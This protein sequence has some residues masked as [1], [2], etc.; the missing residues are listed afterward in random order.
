MHWFALADKE[1]SGHRFEE[2]HAHDARRERSAGT[3]RKDSIDY[4]RVHFSVKVADLFK[5]KV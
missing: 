2:L 4:G 5:E 1:D 3:T